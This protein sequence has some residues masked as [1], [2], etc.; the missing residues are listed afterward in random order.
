MHTL[1]LF[2]RRL[3]TNFLILDDKANSYGNEQP[4]EERGW[5]TETLRLSFT[6]FRQGI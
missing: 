3:L 5:A 6:I 2:G 4:Y 1:L